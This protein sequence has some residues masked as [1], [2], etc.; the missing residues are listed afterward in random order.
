VA[1]VTSSCARWIDERIRTLPPPDGPDV[2]IVSRRSDTASP[3]PSTIVA[4]TPRARRRSYHAEMAAEVSAPRRG[5]A[6]EGDGE[7]E[8]HGGG[9]GSRRH[10]QP[11]APS[12]Q[13]SV[14]SGG[15]F[16]ERR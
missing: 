6:H 1:A 3:L 12:H 14:G 11:P 8:R 16:A 4:S 5:E 7:P 13:D 15:A 2:P 10:E 9:H